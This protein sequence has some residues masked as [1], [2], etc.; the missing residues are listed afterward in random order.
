MQK[1]S[2][3]KNLY[4]AQWAGRDPGDGDQP[5]GCIPRPPRHQAHQQRPIQSFQAR[6]LGRRAPSPGSSLGPVLC[7]I[8][9]R[10]PADSSPP[11]WYS[12]PFCG[13]G[14][15]TMMVEPAQGATPTVGLFP[16]QGW[17]AARPPSSLPRPVLTER[18]GGQTGRRT[19]IPRGPMGS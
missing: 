18:G 17:G 3:K 2:R 14:W 4:F 6:E 19:M 13:K 11:V 12:V 8:E 9:L 15:G 5:K 1:W 10:P 16:G 7:C